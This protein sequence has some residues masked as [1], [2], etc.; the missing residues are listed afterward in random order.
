[1]RPASHPKD[2]CGG[3]CEIGREPRLLIGERYT[4]LPRRGDCLASDNIN[5]LFCMVGGF[6]AHVTFVLY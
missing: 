5:F 4:F 2:H 1:M 6:L 3:E